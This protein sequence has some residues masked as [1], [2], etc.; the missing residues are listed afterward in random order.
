MSH[1]M[2]RLKCMRCS[3]VCGRRARNT[4]DARQPLRGLYPPASAFGAEVL[5]LDLTARLTQRS[6][7][8]CLRQTRIVHRH[9]SSRVQAI[10]GPDPLRN[11]LRFARRNKLTSAP[12]IGASPKEAGQLPGRP[13]ST[14]GAR[15]RRRACRGPRTH[16]S[17]AARGE[18][19]PAAGH[20]GM[21]HHGVPGGGRRGQHCLVY[22]VLALLRRLSP[23]PA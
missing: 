16:E 21:V 13:S 14:P 22:V 11:K 2:S 23:F 19:L 10:S 20:E 1:S 15:S 3:R 7:K 17:G 8:G 18:R 4:G 12:H 6:P 9:F 5:G